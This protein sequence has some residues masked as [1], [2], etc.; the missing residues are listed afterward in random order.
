MPWMTRV[1]QYFRK[2][3]RKN[4]VPARKSTEVELGGGVHVPALHVGLEGGL[5]VKRE[6]DTRTVREQPERD[7]DER[8]SDQA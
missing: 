7:T 6:T 3:P 4:A 2:Q 5:K 1:R 8:E